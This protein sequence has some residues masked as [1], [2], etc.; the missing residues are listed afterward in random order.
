MKILRVIIYQPQ[1]HY[2]IPFTY[3]R[4][5]TYP[6]PPYSTVFGFLINLIGIYDQESN[7]Y[8]QLNKLKLSIAGKFESKSTEMIWFRNLLKSAHKDRFKHPQNRF[9]G[10]HIEHFGGQS[11]M[12]IDILNNV[13]II[14]YMYHEDESVLMKIYENLLEPKN[15]LEILHL[16]RA[17]DWIILKDKPVFLNES[18]LSFKR[19]DR[20][21][22]YFFWIP[23][24]IYSFDSYTI[25][26]NNLDGLLFNIPVFSKIENYHQTFN[27][28]GKRTF[29]K[30]M[31]TKLNDGK[32]LNVNLLLD[33]KLCLPI[34]LGDFQ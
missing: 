20:N 33:K 2:R 16:G 10:G 7:D 30:Y 1:A 32:I 11:Q 12:W 14:I 5:H 27:R 8:K 22:G 29:I 17:E 26:F 9:L 3:Q 15:R 4:R 34:F 21:Y 31:R 25:D 19:L 13:E 23:E 24:K 18:D 28:N 6:I